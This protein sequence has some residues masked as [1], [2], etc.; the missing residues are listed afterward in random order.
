VW[1]RGWVEVWLYCSITAALEEGEWPAARP[2]GTLPPGKT[3]YPFYRRLINNDNYI[4]IM[5]T[6]KSEDG[7]A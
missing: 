6:V 3:R 5:I 2:G 1:P 4:I 7:I